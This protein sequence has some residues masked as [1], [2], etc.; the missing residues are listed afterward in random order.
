MA[1]GVEK[2]DLITYV[3]RILEALARGNSIEIKRNKDGILL[4]EISRK[5]VS[6]K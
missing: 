1:L 2:E 4:L 5:V 6:I 3:P